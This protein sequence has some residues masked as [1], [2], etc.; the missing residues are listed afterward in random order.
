MATQPRD[1]FD[2]VPDDLVRVGAHRAPARRGRGWVKF[3]WAA[4]VTAVL[5][6]AGL[7]GLSR[8]NPD[9]SFDLPN[10]GGGP[11]AGETE[12]PAPVVVPVTDPTQ[13]DPA[14]NLSI[15]VLNGSP[16]NKQAEAAANQIALAGWPTPAAANSTSREEKVTKIYYSSSDFEGIALGLAQLLGTDPANIVLSDFYPGAPVTIILGADYVPPAP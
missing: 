15:S 16:T 14:L 10:F 2:D 11:T 9:V 1:R 7:Y 4:L 3:A 6:V 12:S 8:V 13:V 5:I